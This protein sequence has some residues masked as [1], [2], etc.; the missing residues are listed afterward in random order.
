MIADLK[1]PANLKVNVGKTRHSSKRGARRVTG[2]V[3]GSDGRS[4]IGRAMKRKIRALIHGID[5]L[6][7][8]TRASLAGMIAY[9]TGFDPDFMNSLIAKYGLSTVHHAMTAP[10]AAK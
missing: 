6:D 2:I 5:S 8:K 7:P 1:L 3:L 4:H 9:A 10:V